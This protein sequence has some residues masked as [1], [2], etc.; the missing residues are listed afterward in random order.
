[1]ADSCT[2]AVDVFHTICNRLSA[3]AVDLRLMVETT[4]SFEEWLI[5]ETFLACKLRQE[6]YPFCEVAARPTY[7]S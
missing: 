5:W 3:K 4:S 7:A 2:F 6:S 1:M